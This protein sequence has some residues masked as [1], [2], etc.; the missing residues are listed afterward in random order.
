MNNITAHYSLW[1]QA[2]Q[3]FIDF[4]NLHPYWQESHRLN[5]QPGM[6]SIPG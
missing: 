4:P 6:L 2:L 1:Q 5:Y 3:R